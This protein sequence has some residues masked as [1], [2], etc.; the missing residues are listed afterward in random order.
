MIGRVG[1]RTATDPDQRERFIRDAGIR[2]APVAAPAWRQRLPVQGCPEEAT[3]AAEGAGAVRIRSPWRGVR[4]RERGPPE[5][6]VV[7]ASRS[8]QRHSGGEPC[9]R[10]NCRSYTHGGPHA[11]APSGDV[12]SRTGPAAHLARPNG[13][14]TVVPV[15]FRPDRARPAADPAATS[16]ARDAPLRQVRTR[17]EVYRGSSL[18]WAS[19]GVSRGA[20]GA[21]RILRSAPF[22]TPRMRLLLATPVYDPVDVG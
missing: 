11:K 9:A 13:I 18:S 8:R 22:C 4:R 12:Q 19:T 16:L 5:S 2:Q 6:S 15:V 14:A 7:S 1:C 17:R 10:W 20:R 3:A 21:E